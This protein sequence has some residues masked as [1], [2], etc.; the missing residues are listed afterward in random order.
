MNFVFV[1][2][3]QWNET[4]NEIALADVQ[5]LLGTLNLKI[6]GEPVDFRQDDIPVQLWFSSDD[7]SN[8]GCRQLPEPIPLIGKGELWQNRLPEFLPRRFFEGL[9]EGDDITLSIRGV[10]VQFTAS[11]KRSR[12][13]RFGKFEDAF[14][15]VL[16]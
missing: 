10:E 5:R 4:L 12:Y 13:C 15:H 9:H 2:P 6:N 3:N 14:E 16:G 1:V 8:W 11:Q 7:C